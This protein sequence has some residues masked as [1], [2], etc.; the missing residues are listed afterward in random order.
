VDGAAGVEPVGWSHLKQSNRKFC[1][2]ALRALDT[3]YAAYH[4]RRPNSL[5]GE[6]II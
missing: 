4:E 3:T 1:F 6:H 5:A 2:T